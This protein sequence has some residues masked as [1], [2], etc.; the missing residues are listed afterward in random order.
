MALKKLRHHK[1]LNDEV[2][3]TLRAQICSQDRGIKGSGILSLYIERLMDVDFNYIS[4]TRIIT[5]LSRRNLFESGMVFQPI[6]C[7]RHWLLATADLRTGNIYHDDSIRSTHGN[8]NR[9][10]ATLLKD[11][12]KD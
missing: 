5:Q 6:G 11:L 10:G 1:Q 2:I 7:N 12:L 8:R 3:D 9:D 4:D